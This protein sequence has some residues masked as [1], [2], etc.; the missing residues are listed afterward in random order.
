MTNRNLMTI[1]AVLGIIVLA[2]LAA[3]QAA[4]PK[5]FL[6]SWKGT[7]SIAGAELE[8]GLNF[9]LD[10]AK[11]VVGTFDSITQGAFGLGL[12]AIEIKDKT[13]TCQI[14]G[15]PGDPTIKGTIDETGKK[16]AGEFVQGGYAGTVALEKQ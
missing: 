15:V 7:L 6:G 1:A 13:V 4:D 12:T 2:G 8:I 10:E 3:A 11:K 5:P 16:M 9:K 14:E